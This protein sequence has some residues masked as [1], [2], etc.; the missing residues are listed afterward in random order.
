MN[1]FKEFKIPQT[2]DL[3][4]LTKLQN[5]CTFRRKIEILPISA[6]NQLWKL[7]HIVH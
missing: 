5:G 7:S 6:A 4:I 1:N 2:P 3:L